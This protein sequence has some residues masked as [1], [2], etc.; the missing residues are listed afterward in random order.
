MKES[1]GAILCPRKDVSEHL[2]CNVTYDKASVKPYGMTVK[3]LG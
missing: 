3:K 2:Q 1:T